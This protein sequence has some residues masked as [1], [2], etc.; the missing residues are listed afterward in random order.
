MNKFR[1]QLILRLQSVPYSTGKYNEKYNEKLAQT[2]VGVPVVGSHRQ[3]Y[4]GR[5]VAGAANTVER[6]PLPSIGTLSR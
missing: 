4:S 2:E 3:Q 5:V 6:M 1:W